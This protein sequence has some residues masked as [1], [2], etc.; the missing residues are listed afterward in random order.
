MPPISPPQKRC[1]SC[2]CLLAPKCL[3]WL[4]PTGGGVYVEWVYQSVCVCVCAS[5]QCSSEAERIRANRLIA[6]V[7]GK[8][9]KSTRELG[10]DITEDRDSLPRVEG[11]GQR[12]SESVGN[13]F[14][15]QIKSTARCFPKAPNKRGCMWVGT[16]ENKKKIKKIEN[17]ERGTYRG[18]HYTQVQC[19]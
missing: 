5:S 1:S 8:A 18:E 19:Q 7:A 15:K 2:V 9:W 10:V 13:R 4:P 11:D 16:L 6:K 17:K 3:K 14:E 12:Q